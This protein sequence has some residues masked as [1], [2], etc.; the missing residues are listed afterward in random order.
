MIKISNLFSDSIQDTNEIEMSTFATITIP[1]SQETKAFAKYDEI[2]D[3]Y[4][5]GKN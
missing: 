4:P 2:L 5:E 1:T 3:Y